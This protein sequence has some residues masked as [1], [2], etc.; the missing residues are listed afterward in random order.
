M[1]VL[2][3][4]VIQNMIIKDQLFIVVFFLMLI[5]LTFQLVS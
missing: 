5:S 3:G 2:K 1:A 4:P